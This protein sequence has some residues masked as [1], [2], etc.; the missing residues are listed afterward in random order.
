MGQDDPLGGP[1]RPG[2]G[3]DEGVAVLDVRCAG[4]A[5]RLASLVDDDGGAERLDEGAP[6]RLGKA[7][8]EGQDGVAVVVA[9]L[10]RLDE[11]LRRRDVEGDEAAHGG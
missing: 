2:G 3:E 5:V 8:V 6:G 9:A 10:H 1:G 11:A 4:Q 7:I